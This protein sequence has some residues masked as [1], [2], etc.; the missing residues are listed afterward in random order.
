MIVSPH[1]G[2]A[3]GGL[4]ARPGEAAL[5]TEEAFAEAWDR[6][7]PGGWLAWIAGDEQVFLRGIMAIWAARAAADPTAGA[8]G[9]EAW[10]WRLLQ[11][12]APAS[13]YRLLCL[14]P[15]TAAG[16]SAPDL[17]R[18]S[19]AQPLRELFGPGADVKSRYVPLLDPAGPASARELLARQFSGRAA[20]HRIV[21][22][23]TDDGAPVFDYQAG[24]PL[25]ENVILAVCSLALLAILL[26][27]LGARRQVGSPEADRDVPLPLRLGETPVGALLAGVGV[28][29]AVRAV[30][31]RGGADPALFALP[32]SAAA[33]LLLPWLVRPRIAGLAVALFAAVLLAADP[34]SLDPGVRLVV[35]SAL[36]LAFGM[37]AGS[38]LRAALAGADPAEAR[39]LVLGWL[40]AAAGS[41]ALAGRLV[42]DVGAART[43]TLVA[44]GWAVAL[45]GRL[46]LAR[47]RR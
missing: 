31:F 9:A 38:Q 36:A 25:G 10:G 21:D 7:A 22:P 1:G 40:V 33:G 6:V 23:A 28:A 46:L 35:G 15:R 45:A 29:L 34:G 27:P 13:P 11:S 47:L 43:A 26:L 42:H 4:R 39:W 14:V 30:T 8:L 37:G 12:E 17:L 32:A 16:A 24:R 18:A 44:S 20:E 19:R 41:A 5:Y 2:G 3:R